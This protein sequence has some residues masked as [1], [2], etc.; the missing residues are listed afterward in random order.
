MGLLPLALINENISEFIRGAS[1]MDEAT[2]IS[3]FKN[4]PAALLSIQQ[5]YYHPH[6]I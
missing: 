4:N 6:G 1:L 2:R 5:H 3:D